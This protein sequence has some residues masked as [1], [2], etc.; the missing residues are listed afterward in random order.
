[1]RKTWWASPAVVAAVAAVLVTGCDSAGQADSQQKPATSA[2]P[3]PS[4]TSAAFGRTAAQS[5]IDGATAAAGLPASG[6]PEPAPST[7]PAGSSTERD[8]LKARAAAC[9]AHWMSADAELREIGDPRGKFDA[10]T[11]ELL[12][13]GWRVTT[14]RREDKADAKADDT[15]GAKSSTVSIT[16]KK[17]G[18]TLMGRHH[19]LG[20]V[21]MVSFQA[22]EDA[23]MNRF[24]KRE[25]ELIL[26]QEG[27]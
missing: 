27:L 5:D 25:W 20:S 19:D 7:P 15:A 16:L 11:A 3:E 17:S 21:D 2:T 12:K 24:T 14:D 22:S 6:R 13:R 26:N 1:M 4:A 8:R 9:S 10:T 18:W 23:C